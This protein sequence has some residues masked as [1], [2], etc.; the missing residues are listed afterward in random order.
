VRSSS[1]IKNILP[2]YLC[3]RVLT[4]EF[5]G[6]GHV[7]HPRNFS[8]VLPAKSPAYGVLVKYKRR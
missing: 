2:A 4:F 3:P 7:V 5:N 6:L 8:L 1:P